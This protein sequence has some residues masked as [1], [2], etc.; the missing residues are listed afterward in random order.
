[1]RLM[2]TAVFFAFFLATSML[3]GCG[4]GDHA[5]PP[6]EN[7]STWLVTGAVD[8]DP[9]C[10][11]RGTV[12]LTGSSA[13]YIEKAVHGPVT[14]EAVLTAACD[15]ADGIL[16]LGISEAGAGVASQK[17]QLASQTLRASWASTSSLGVTLGLQAAHPCDVGVGIVIK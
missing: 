4:G 9:S 11:S 16:V 6:G 1:M 14:A 17:G 3:A 8:I 13:A 12:H 5:C 15:P 7:L 2:L 10:P